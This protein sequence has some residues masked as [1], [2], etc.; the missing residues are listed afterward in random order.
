MPR[1]SPEQW[2]VVVVLPELV[3]TAVL[4]KMGEMGSTESV[5]WGARQIS[6]PRQKLILNRCSEYCKKTNNVVLR[7]ERHTC[8]RVNTLN[9]NW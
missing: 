8:Y 4:M 1:R 3:G 5:G 7:F 9:S 6:S 2:L